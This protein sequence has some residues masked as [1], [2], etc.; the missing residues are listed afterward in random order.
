MY[1]ATT[2]RSNRLISQVLNA[3]LVFGALYLPPLPTPA[4][5]AHGESLRQRALGPSATTTSERPIGQCIY[6]CGDRQIILRRCPD[7]DCPE[8]DCQTG[9]VNCGSR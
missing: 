3:L 2:S 8:Y 6:V 9:T 4:H 1:G 7:G 5:P